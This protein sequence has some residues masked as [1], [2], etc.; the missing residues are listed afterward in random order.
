VAGH[1]GRDAPTLLLANP[2]NPDGR[3]VPPETCATA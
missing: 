1:D 3:I 2:N